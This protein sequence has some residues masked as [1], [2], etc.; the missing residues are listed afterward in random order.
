MTKP[1]KSVLLL[2]YPGFLPIRPF[3]I[4][5]QAYKSN[6]KRSQ[7]HV[8]IPDIPIL[9]PDKTQNITEITR[10][11]QL[12]DRKKQA[13]SHCLKRTQGGVTKQYA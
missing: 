4:S 12:M 13:L 10:V 8:L 6:T 2:S 9:L 3:I 7:N 5:F 1:H 11:Q